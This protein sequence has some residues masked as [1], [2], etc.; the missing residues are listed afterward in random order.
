M[1]VQGYPQRT[2]DQIR[3]HWK[4]ECLLDSFNLLDSRPE[5]DRVSVYTT[6]LSKQDRTQRPT[7]SVSQRTFAGCLANIAPQTIVQYVRFN[8][9]PGCVEEATQS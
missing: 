5:V 9:H 8:V 3:A 2:S 4:A 7:A 6:V 1:F